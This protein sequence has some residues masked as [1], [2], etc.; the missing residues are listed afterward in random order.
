MSPW[1]TTAKTTGTSPLWK[2]SC[3]TTRRSGT[4]PS[5]LEQRTVVVILTLVCLGKQRFRAWSFTCTHTCGCTVGPGCSSWSRK[6]NRADRRWN[7][8]STPLNLLT[9]ADKGHQFLLSDEP[10]HQSTIHQ[11][12]T[13]HPDPR[14]WW[15]WKL[16]IVNCDSSETSRPLI[17]PLLSE[18]TRSRTRLITASTNQSCV[19]LFV[20][21]KETTWVL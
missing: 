5:K 10:Q 2:D 8:S 11:P 14:S 17:Y 12:G 16:K 21:Y 3:L 15:L 20:K 7:K 9:W 18:G 19:C 4:G 13:K 1:S 6:Q